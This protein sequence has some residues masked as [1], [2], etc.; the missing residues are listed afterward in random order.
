MPLFLPCVDGGAPCRILSCCVHHSILL[1]WLLHRVRW[2]EKNFLKFQCQGWHPPIGARISKPNQTSTRVEMTFSWI[3]RS[4][5][6]ARSHV[7]DQNDM[8]KKEWTPC[9]VLG[10]NWWFK[11][12]TRAPCRVHEGT[13]T[14]T[15]IWLDDRCEPRSTFCWKW[16]ICKQYLG[17]LAGIWKQQG[18]LTFIKSWRST[19]HRAR[20][21]LVVAMRLQT[22]HL[23]S[24]LCTSCNMPSVQ[25]KIT[26][27]TSLLIF[28]EG[29][30]NFHLANFVL[31]SI[32]AK[33]HNSRWCCN[34][35]QLI[36]QSELTPTW[37]LTQGLRHGSTQKNGVMLRTIG[38]RGSKALSELIP[39][40]P[41]MIVVSGVVRV[42]D[43]HPTYQDCKLT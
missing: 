39:L 33:R 37:L 34:L 8:T 15:M 18:K 25:K 7:R 17:K 36:N 31:K 14:T 11:S 40:F 19:K 3:N 6:G 2:M 13:R 1:T 16:S 22:Q 43:D 38:H 24:Q 23:P 10:Q 30:R 35:E 27:V 12:A 26:N 32:W 42:Y 9:R 28:S 4:R 41:R 29:K 5:R 20:T 21:Q